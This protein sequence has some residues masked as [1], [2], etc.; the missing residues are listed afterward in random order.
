MNHK[1]VISSDI[2]EQSMC[3]IFYLKVFQA[4]K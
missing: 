4:Q 1:M 2:L 3:N